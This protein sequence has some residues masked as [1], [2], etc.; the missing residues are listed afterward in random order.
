VARLA[1]SLDLGSMVSFNDVGVRLP[2][3][4]RRGGGGRRQRLRRFAGE[5]RRDEVWYLNDATFE[6][7]EGESLAIVGHRESGRDELLRL[8]AGTLIPDT[9]TV[10]RR[11]NV[12]PMVGLRGALNRQYTV[13]QNVYLVSGLLGMTKEE[14]TERLDE[15][16][17]RAGVDRILDKYLADT[18]ANVRGRLSWSIAIATRARAFAIAQSLIVGEP[19]FHQTCWQVMEE[20]KADGVTFLVS[21][22]KPAE[23]LR[24]CDRALLLD[25]GRV[26]AQ[27]TVEDALDQL[28]RIKPPAGHRNFVIEELTD[29]DEDDLM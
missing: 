27:T 15:I 4:Q 7:A 13:R 6:V 9:G 14:T 24:F 8:A 16:V 17:E 5:V 20:M 29:Q 25:A 21:S 1:L 12:I 19:G 3:R 23:L 28:T 22:D 26:V 11:A 2:R 18:P 10:R